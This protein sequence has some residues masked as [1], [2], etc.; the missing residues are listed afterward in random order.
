M[1]KLCHGP[2]LLYEV[3][4][5]RLRNTINELFES[6]QRSPLNCVMVHCSCVK[7]NQTMVCVAVEIDN[8]DL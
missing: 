1:N 6:G 2:V 5:S 3:Q 4:G 7:K 8:K